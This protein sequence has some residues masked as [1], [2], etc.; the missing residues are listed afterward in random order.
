MRSRRRNYSFA[1]SE[2]LIS[3]FPPTAYAVGCI[4]SPVRGWETLPRTSVPAFHMPPLRG[5]I[6]DAILS[7]NGRGKRA[8]RRHRGI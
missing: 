4:L 5:F 6:R 2:L 7:L 1:P 3:H 8:L